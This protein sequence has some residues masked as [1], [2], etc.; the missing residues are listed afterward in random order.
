MRLD[1]GLLLQ[2]DTFSERMKESVTE[3]IGRAIALLAVIV[4]AIFTFTEVAFVDI[5]LEKF[6]VESVVAH[7]I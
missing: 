6:T 7:N 3:H 5:S 1:D 4:C 2:A